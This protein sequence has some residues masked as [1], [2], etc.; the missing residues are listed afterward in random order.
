MKSQIHPL[1]Y[2]SR[3]GHCGAKSTPFTGDLGNTHAVP[4]IPE[5]R[6]REY[7]KHVCHLH[8]QCR[9]QR[10]KCS[11]VWPF[12]SHDEW[13]F[14]QTP[15]IFFH[16]LHHKMEVYASNLSS[17]EIHEKCENFLSWIIVC[18]YT[19][20]KQTTTHTYQTDS[21]THIQKNTHTKSRNPPCFHWFLQLFHHSIRQLTVIYPI[22]PCPLDGRREVIVG[23]KKVNEFNLDGL[24]VSNGWRQKLLPNILSHRL[25]RKW[26]K[27]ARQ[28]QSR[29]SSSTKSTWLNTVQ[30]QTQY[31]KKH[32]RINDFLMGKSYKAQL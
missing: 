31:G 28:C 1:F 20:T 27:F 5:W 14:L 2:N 9:S 24:V 11:E 10:K 4:P 29:P 30:T 18:G 19:L 32:L 7:N 16:H 13:K 17:V 12:I 25:L 6:G 23:H 8:Q 26:V 15:K 22:M 21:H 3:A